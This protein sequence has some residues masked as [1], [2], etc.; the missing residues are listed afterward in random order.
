MLGPTY[1]FFTVYWNFFFFLAGATARPSHYVA[2]LPPLFIHG[3]SFTASTTTNPSP[4]TPSPISGSASLPTLPSP[5]TTLLP[6]PA[7]SLP[8]HPPS[9]TFS[10]IM[11][12]YH[13]LLSGWELT[14]DWSPVWAFIN[15]RRCI[16]WNEGSPN[17]AEFNSEFNRG[18]F[19][20]IYIY[21]YISNYMYAFYF[22]LLLYVCF[23]PQQ[24]FHNRV[25]YFFMVQFYC[26]C[27]LFTT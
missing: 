24:E 4:S 22:Y 16:C 8:P 11:V 19:L 23:L 5:T 2:P 21:I 14:L 20:Y 18:I 1:F 10:F 25:L 27:H 3:F 6:P 12:L 26:F 13:C 15:W 17:S 7:S 9:H